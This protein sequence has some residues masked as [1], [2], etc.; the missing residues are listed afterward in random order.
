MTMSTN[1]R[2]DALR[3]AGRRS[4]DQ[5]A[6]LRR[7]AAGWTAIDFRA[8]TRIRML[9]PGEPAIARAQFPEEYGRTSM[10]ML[11][12]AGLVVDDRGHRQRGSATWRLTP[13]G[14]AAA[15]ELAE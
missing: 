7:L 1:A 5:E 8:G 6:I 2:R 15:A 4:P 10:L 12:S 9:P 11:R 14:H 13:D 3:A